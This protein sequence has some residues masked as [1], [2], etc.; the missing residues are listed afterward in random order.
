M[1]IDPQFKT[2]VGIC[3]GCGAR[4]R[5]QNKVQL[6]EFI[7]CAECG[8]ELEVVQL[9]PVKLDW[10][11]E[12]PFDEDEYDGDFEDDYDDDDDYDYDDDYDDDDDDDEW[13]D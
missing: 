2:E 9:S 1:T 7:I 6:G 11:F 3:P 5:F 12:D 13:D 10:A 4:I 8:D